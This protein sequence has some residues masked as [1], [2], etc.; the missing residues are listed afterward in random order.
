VWP[1]AASSDS[2]RDSGCD[3]RPA[4]PGNAAPPTVPAEPYGLAELPD[5]A[6]PCAPRAPA[7]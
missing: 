4:V 6:A 3:T 1:A 7:P 2:W 5:P